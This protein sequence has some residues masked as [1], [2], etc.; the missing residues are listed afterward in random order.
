LRIRSGQRDNAFSLVELLLTLVLILCIAAASVFSYTALHRTAN[1][2]EGLDRFES[3]IRFAQAEA[4]TTGRKVRLQFEAAPPEAAPAAQEESRAELREI[5]VTWEEDFLNAPGVFEQYTNKAWSE[6]MVNEIVGVEKVRSIQPDGAAN[7]SEFTPIGEEAA[8]ASTEIA[9]T[10]DAQ[11]ETYGTEFPSITF[12]PDGSCDSAEIVLASRNEEDHR[13]LEVRLSGILGSVSSRVVSVSED[14]FADAFDESGESS[15][16]S[17]TPEYA[18]DS[19][20][21]ADPFGQ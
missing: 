9:E 19:S 1:L 7:V 20:F 6:A 5:R 4:A 3:L 18:D 14:E 12:Y 2:D 17:T 13:R 10:E 15:E 11:A 21:T 16:M 8:L